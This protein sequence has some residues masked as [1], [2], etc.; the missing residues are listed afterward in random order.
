MNNPKTDYDNVFELIGYC[1]GMG[2]TIG[3]ALLI[4][5]LVL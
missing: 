1:I 2:L 5:K 3:V 4:C